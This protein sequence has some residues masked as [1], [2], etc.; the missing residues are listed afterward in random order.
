MFRDGREYVA[1][2][3]V[4]DVITDNGLGFLDSCAGDR[5]P[6]YLSL[7]YTAPHDPWT[8]ENHPDELYD[9]YLSD[10]P[11]ESVPFVPMHPWQ[12]RKVQPWGDEGYRRHCLS[13]YFAAVTAMDRNIGRVLDW[14]E[15]NRLREN[16]LVFFTSDNG[17]NM[18]HHGIY[19]KGNGTFPQNMFDT[20]VIVPGLVSRPGHVP[21][22]QTCDALVS[23]YDW[24]PTLLGYLDL[25]NPDAEQLPGRSFAGIL[26]GAA[27]V[28]REDV[29]VYDEYGPVRM[30]RTREW[31]YIHRY[32]YGPH[33]LYDLRSD[34]GEEN[35]LYSQEAWKHQ[36]AELRGRLEAWFVR[37]VDPSFDGSREAVSGKG[38]LG[39]AGTAARGA[40]R[41][42]Q[43][44]VYEATGDQSRQP[45]MNRKNAAPA[46]GVPR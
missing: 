41:F 16:T 5:Q 34:P 2:G 12:V 32:P 40:E 36:V 46:E 30:I 29:V 42:A 8:R 37:F 11:F 24:M 44:W 3:Y 7:H 13:G 33:E 1:P 25:E 9:A 31:K 39:L 35:D 10:C 28:A 43:D 14:L 45:Y 18:G 23:H 4:T 15:A 22:G 26:R 17:M 20:S 27:I 21:Q 38:Q 19:G 6:F